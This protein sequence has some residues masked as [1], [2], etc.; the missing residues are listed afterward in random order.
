M[1]RLAVATLAILCSTTALSQT[2]PSK[3]LTLVAP[4][5]PGGS[6]DVIARLFASHLS[7]RLGQPVVVENKPGSNGAIGAAS[8]ARAKPDG[9]TL[10]VMGASSFTI[11]PLLYK[12]LNY[13]PVDSYDYLGIAGGTQLVFLTTA[14]TGIGSVADIVTK[15]ASEPL[16]YGS[17]GTG[18]LPQIAGEYLAQKTGA[19]LLHVPYRGSSPAMTDLIGNQIPLSI[20]TVVAA[21]PQI[22]GG[23][24]IPLAV[25][26]GQRS[27]RLPDVPSVQETGIAN[28]DFETWFGIVSPK[29][30]P[31]EI[32][33]RL[34]R[35]IREMMNEK[36]TREALEAIG[37]DAR[38]SDPHQFKEQ[39]TMELKRNA[40]IIKAANIKV[41]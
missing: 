38:Y 8:V 30:T 23:R 40:G 35:E 15:S 36:S 31:P 5:P 18:S 29:G 1:I 3:P 21:M 14:A 17:F 34:S 4:F 13:D 28:Y 27:A 7:D 25:S 26:S 2:Y 9:Y 12:N 22:Q 6:T 41:D 20:D 16:S 33:E 32:V 24:V 19:Q 39:V 10:L 37:F 11:N